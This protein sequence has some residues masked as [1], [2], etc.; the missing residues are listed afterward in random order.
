L[1]NFLKVGLIIV[2]IFTGLAFLLVG[3]SFFVLA[4]AITSGGAEE[5]ELSSTYSK[6]AVVEVNE[7]IMSSESTIRQLKK[8][9]KNTSVKAIVVR[10][11]SPGGGVAASQE[12]Y[13]EIK[14]INKNGKPVVISMGGIAASGGYYISLGASKIIA[15]P[16]TL[17]GSIG[18]IFQYPNVKN[19]FNKIGVDM[20]T[21]KSGKMKDA[22]SPYRTPNPDDQTYFQ[23]LIDNTYEQFTLA[24]SESRNIP[25]EEVKKF[26]DGR[27]FT[28]MQA[29]EMKLIDTLGTYEDA[30]RI[31]AKLGGISGEPKIL[32]EKKKQTL[33]EKLDMKSFGNPLEKFDGLF[34]EPASQY[35]FTK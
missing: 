21:V 20:V 16:G 6:V 23:G 29:Y 18:V 14:R 24:V 31:A 3:I 19:L 25:I 35:K 15:N 5:E 22:G 11:E 32:K 4:G 2:G 30:I 17:T 12:I 7:A 33:W 9:Y 1:N 13:E 27:V 10:V 28:G 8:Y 34:E 26:S